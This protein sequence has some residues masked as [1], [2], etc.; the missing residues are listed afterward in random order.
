MV[1]LYVLVMLSGMYNCHEDDTRPPS[2]SGMISSDDGSIVLIT[3]NQGE[4][5][6]NERGITIRKH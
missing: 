5:A 2:L 6:T 4:H 3:G 1:F